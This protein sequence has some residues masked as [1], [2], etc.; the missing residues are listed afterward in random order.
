[1]LTLFQFSDYDILSQQNTYHQNNYNL[2]YHCSPC[3]ITRTTM[4]IREQISSTV[5]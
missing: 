5:N 4:K 1:M 2:I 3:M